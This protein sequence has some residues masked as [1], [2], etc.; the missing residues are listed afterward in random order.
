MKTLVAAAMIFGLCV[1]LPTGAAESPA[2]PSPVIAP[3]VEL[4]PPAPPLDALKACLAKPGNDECLE[5]LYRAELEK[6]SPGDLL[7]S[8]RRYEEQDAGLRLACHPVV[9]AL[10]REIFRVKG[11]IHDAFLAC[12]QTCHSGCY[13][14]AVERFL[15]GDSKAPARHVTESE[16]LRKVPTACDAKAERRVYFQ[17]LHGLGHALMYFTENEVDTSLKGC[18]ALA[19][20]WSRDSCYGGVFMENVVSS[21][22]E[23]RMVSETDPHYPCN[24]VAEKYRGACYLMQTSRMQEMGLTEQQQFD[25]CAK[26]GRFAADCAQSIGRDLSNLS[27]TGES[28]TAAAACESAG[29]EARRACIRGAVYALIDNTWDL[30]YATPFCAALKEESGYCTQTSGDYLKMFMGK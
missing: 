17:C 12:D 11:N 23:K 30:T 6:R 25:E 20:G 5:L 19:D 29:G 15:R 7:D 8:V 24:R 21:L 10:G 2:P 1:P 14:G 4:P 27:R 26:T 3:A 22:A 18:D 28:A 16:I 9:H 13:H